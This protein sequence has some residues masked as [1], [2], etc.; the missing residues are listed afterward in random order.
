MKNTISLN[1]NEQF[2]TV[3]RNGKRS[4]HKY[5]TLYY[6]P[7][8]M[9]I[10]RLGFRVGKKLAKA[11]KRNRLRRLLKESYRLSESKIKLGYDFILAARDG[12]LNIDSL[13]ETARITDRL[14]GRA[15]LF[16]ST[17]SSKKL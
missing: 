14:F 2:L 9:D 11:V 7:N 1:K 6:L 3:Y 13:D 15:G 5:F 10:N 16:L 4:Y 8:G 12:S 17:V